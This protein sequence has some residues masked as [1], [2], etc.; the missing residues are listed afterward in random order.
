VC[1]AD[2]SNP[3]QL[4]AFGSDVTAAGR[5]SPD[6]QQIVFVSNKEG[7]QEIYVMRSGGGAARRLTNNPAHESAPS[8]SRDGRWIYFA[9][10]RTDGFQVWKV[11]AAGTGDPVRVTRGG[12]YGAIESLDG[13]MLY[14]SK[15]DE[16]AVW[17]VWEMPAAGGPEKQLI[18][19]I[20]TWGDFDVSAV[21]VYYIDAARAGA[22]IRLHRFSDG[23]D[24]VL[25]TVEKRPS[26]GLTVSPDDRTILYSQFDQEL[27]ELMLLDR[28]QIR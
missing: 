24:L 13:K 15:R 21:G 1:G 18:R 12:G 23:A 6:G 11:T 20:G 22:K 25:G 7:Q 27:T 8:W 4:T 9:S 5:W 14:Y 17:A 19:S 28:I 26:F 10:N 16:H 3:V 2:G